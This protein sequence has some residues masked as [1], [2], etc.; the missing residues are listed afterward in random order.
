MKQNISK[1]YIQA[2]LESN[3]GPSEHLNIPMIHA[4]VSAYAL[5]FLLVNK[6]AI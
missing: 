5:G 1:I 3:S 4:T 6:V 2:F